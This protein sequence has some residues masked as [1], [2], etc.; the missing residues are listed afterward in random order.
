MI[1]GIMFAVMLVLLLLEVPVAVSI[2]ISSFTALLIDG[3]IPLS[4]IPQRV[5]NAV[6]SFSLLAL[7]FFMLAG[8]FMEHG[9][10]TKKMVNFANAVVG[11]ATG[12]L[13]YVSVVAGMIMGGISGSCSADTAALSSIMI[14]AMS[15]KG[16]KKGFSAA[17]QAAS[18]CL[19]LIIPPSIPMI[20]MGGITGIS[21]AKLFV[22]GIIPGIVVSIAL[23]ITARIVCI[24]QGMGVHDKTPFTLKNVWR[25]FK[26]AFLT[27]LAPLIIMG[28][29]LG[30]VFTA[31]DDSVVA[32]VYTFI[33]GFFVY[34]EIKLKD[35][36]KILHEA[37]RKTGSVLIIVASAS[38]FSWLLTINNVHITMTNWIF[39]ISDNP[40][41]IMF[42]MMFIF[43]VLAMFIDETPLI[44]M[45]LPIML[46]IAEK[47]GID[48]MLFCILMVVNNAIGGIM[49]PVGTAVF[50]A[51]ASC[52]IKTSETIK[53]IFPFVLAYIICLIL[54]YVF[55]QLVLWLPS[56]T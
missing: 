5:L 38:I 26:E 9:G 4:I 8:S 53:Q 45:L 30:G 51:S 50:V 48:P 18:G 24:R 31:T 7:P 36:V 23:M 25:T 33:I 44:I 32:A 29:I 22:A 52:G 47:V 12:G 27:L 19:G 1:I 35:L 55:P 13:S 11:W 41:V 2:G 16:Y 6:N 46:P 21:V 37:G 43:F 54:L 14:P 49:P 56:T 3:S 15:E 20:I 39:A 28:G 40:A 10:L 42:L 17:L 34:K